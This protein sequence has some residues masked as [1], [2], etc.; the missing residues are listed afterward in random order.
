MVNIRLPR[1]RLQQNSD[2]LLGALQS[3]GIVDVFDK[4]KADLSGMSLDK[5]HVNDI[6]HKYL[7]PLIF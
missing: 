7:L 1:F 5:L 4:K 3:M 6:F 2:G